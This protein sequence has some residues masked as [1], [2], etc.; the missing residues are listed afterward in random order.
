MTPASGQPC[1]FR[2]SSGPF[3]SWAALGS[4]GSASQPAS[5]LSSSG[6]RPM[7]SI[8][9]ASPSAAASVTEFSVPV[10]RPQVPAKDTPTRRPSVACSARKSAT[11]PVPS[12]RTEMSKP[13]AASGSA[14]V[15][16]ANS[17]S[18]S[19]RNCRLSKS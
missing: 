2:A 17:R 18:R 19:T 9:P 7:T 16:V 11:A 15:R 12:R 10:P 4:S 8:Q 1:C 6:L 13:S 5:A 14:V 3:T